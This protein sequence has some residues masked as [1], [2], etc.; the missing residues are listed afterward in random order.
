MKPDTGWGDV[1]LTS[2]FVIMSYR[3]VDVK[4]PMMLK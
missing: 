2:S 1:A 4:V 3:E